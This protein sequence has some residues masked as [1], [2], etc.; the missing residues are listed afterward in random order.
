MIRWKAQGWGLVRWARQES[1]D[2]V[3]HM[4]RSRTVLVL[5][6][7][8]ATCTCRMG[9]ILAVPTVVKYMRACVA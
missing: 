4:R 7:E 3:P 2:A 8:M 9:C 5:A 1:N 6:T